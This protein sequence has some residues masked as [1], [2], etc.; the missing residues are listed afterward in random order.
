MRAASRQLRSLHGFTVVELLVV[1]AVLALLLSIAAPRYIQHL[2]KAREITLK[3]DLRQMRDAIDKFYND[4]GRYPESLIELV[5]RSYLRSIP[6]DPVTEREDTWVIV[7]PK[8]SS[9]QDKGVYDVHSGAQERASDGSS[10]A[11]W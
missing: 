9:Q 2:D 3:Q 4:Q 5:E 6:V 1:L 11:K 7:P 8:K 10:Y